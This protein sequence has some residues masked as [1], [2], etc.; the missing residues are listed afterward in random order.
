VHQS[1]TLPDFGVRESCERRLGENRGT[2]AT[3]ECVI[4]HRKTGLE[5]MLLR[6][7]WAALGLGLSLAFLL[8]SHRLGRRTASHGASELAAATAL[9]TKVALFLLLFGTALI[10]IAY[11]AVVL[12][13]G[14]STE[15]GSGE[16]AQAAQ[17]FTDQAL[18]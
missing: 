3:V 1:R 8:T 9:H 14:P 12:W 15:G 4:R 16:S 5:W 17:T 11:A 13:G 6:S 10:A 7:R 2:N 18:R